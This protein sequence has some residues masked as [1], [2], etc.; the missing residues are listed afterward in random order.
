[1]RISDAAAT[2]RMNRRTLSMWASRGLIASLK[3]E[4]ANSHRLVHIDNILAYME[5]QLREAK[6]ASCR[7]SNMSDEGTDTPVES[8][9]EELPGDNHDHH[10]VRPDLNQMQD[11]GCTDNV[12][13]MTSP[14]ITP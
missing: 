7:D 2:F 5:D 3:G 13:I 8:D 10:H 6:E 12:S 14:I 9:E 11:Q 4:G 1:M